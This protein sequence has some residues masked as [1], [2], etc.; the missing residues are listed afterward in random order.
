MAHSMGAPTTLY[1]LTKVVDQKWK[2]TYLR[3]YITISGV[4]HGA[5]KAVKAFASGDNEGIWIVPNSEGRSGQRTYPANA[6][7]L[8]YP[9]DTW[10]SKD[11]L[12]VTPTANY[13]AWDYKALFSAMNYSR[14]YEMFTEIMNLTGALPPPN[15]TLH[16]LYGNQVKTPL[17]FI[18]E[19]GEFPDTQPKT[20]TGNGDGTVNVNSLTACERWKTEQKFG[21]T[22]QPFDGVEHVDTVRND[23]II[24]YVDSVVYNSAQQH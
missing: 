23:D 16:C 6:W 1:F 5:A 22:L 21:V 20:I 24:K 14:G 19:A 9:S 4:W 12:V 7:L 8:P 2:D 17:Q 13:T 10:T 11:V 3:D 15:V 18:Y